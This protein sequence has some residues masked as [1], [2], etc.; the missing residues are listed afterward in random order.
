MSEVFE[1]Q[2]DESTAAVGFGDAATGDVRRGTVDR[3]E[4][5]GNVAIGIDMPLAASPIPR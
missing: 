3:L 4:L 2:S 5:D 1:Q